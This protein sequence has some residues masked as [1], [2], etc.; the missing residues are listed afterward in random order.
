MSTQKNTFFFF[1]KSDIFYAMLLVMSIEE[2]SIRLELSSPP[3]FRIQGGYPECDG[4]TDEE[5]PL[6]NL[7]FLKP[8]SLD[9]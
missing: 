9:S 4:R 3:R 6:S 8:V 1:R 7:G 2:I 5:N